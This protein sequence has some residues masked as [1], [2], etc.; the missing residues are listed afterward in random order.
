[1][2]STGNTQCDRCIHR[3]VCRYIAMI[4]EIKTKYSFITNVGCSFHIRKTA[5]FKQTEPAPEAEQEETPTETTSNKETVMEPHIALTKNDNTQSDEPT[6]EDPYGDCDKDQ[7][8]DETEDSDGPSSI[9]DIAIDKIG[10][11]EQETVDALRRLGIR[12]VNDVY[13]Y[14]E[15]RAWSGVKGL[16]KARVDNLSSILQAFNLPALKPY[17]SKE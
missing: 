11:R 13:T 17:G 4:A 8:S 10:I 3:D 12:T 5:A 7:S 15:T 9:M 14:Q 1:M 16:T 6:S 2:A